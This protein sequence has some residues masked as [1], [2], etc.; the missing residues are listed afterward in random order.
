MHVVLF[1]LSSTTTLDTEAAIV[2][3]GQNTNDTAY[4]LIMKSRPPGAVVPWTALS[5]AARQ[6]STAH[7]RVALTGH[8]SQDHDRWIILYIL[9]LHWHCC[10]SIHSEFSVVIMPVNKIH[11]RQRTWASAQKWEV[12]AQG[13]RVRSHATENKEMKMYFNF[14]KN[15]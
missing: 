7:H 13:Q 1:P 15:W 12:R 14:I 5:I 6:V 10:Q 2:D 8:S 11:P 4:V 9:V 3:A